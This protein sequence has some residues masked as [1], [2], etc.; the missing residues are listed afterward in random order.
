MTGKERA[1]LRSAANKLEPILY[2]GKDGVTENTIKEADDA[3]KARELIKAS[4]QKNCDFSVKEVSMML[5]DETGAECVQ[6]IGRR[7]CLYRKNP[8]EE[9]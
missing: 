4:V 1:E 9:I 8:D 2:I 6:C 7:F 5:C 3:L